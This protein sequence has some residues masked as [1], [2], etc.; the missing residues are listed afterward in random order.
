MR[1][2]RAATPARAKPSP[3][4]DER[5]VG[6]MSQILE[7]LDKGDREAMNEA[8]TRMDGLIRE[9]RERPKS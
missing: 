3:E 6:A 1:R 7:G 2:K 5:A 9:Y 4:W 8:I